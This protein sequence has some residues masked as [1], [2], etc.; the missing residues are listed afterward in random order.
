MGGS[1][2]LWQLT[3]A[4]FREQLRQPEVLFWVF[5]FPLLLVPHLGIVR[6]GVFFGL[7]NT[8]G[9][10]PFIVLI[11][12]WLRGGRHNPRLRPLT[13]APAASC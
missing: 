7:L 5:A 10:L 6:S 4:R 1:S 3:L 13:T 8:L 9:M 12:L 2:P 11:V